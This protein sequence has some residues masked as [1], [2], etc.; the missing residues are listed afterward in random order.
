M[1]I[2]KYYAHIIL[3]ISL[4]NMS[5]KSS[6]IRPAM[7]LQLRSFI[8]WVDCNL[9]KWSLKDLYIASIHQNIRKC[10]NKH[11]YV[12]LGEIFF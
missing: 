4:H 7:L 5:W 12:N 9:S 10:C 3:V 1:P 6:Y 11:T 2:A 8:N